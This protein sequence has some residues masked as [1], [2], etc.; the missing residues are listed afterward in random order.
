MGFLIR[1][2]FYVIGMLFWTMIGGMISIF[3]FFS[4]PIIL[5]LNALSPGYNKALNEA[6]TFAVLRRGYGRLYRFLLYGL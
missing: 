3:N 5:I 2:N 1:L 4:I 6:L